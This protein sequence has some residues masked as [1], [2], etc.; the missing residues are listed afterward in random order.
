MAECRAEQ[1]R[2]A[3]PGRASWRSVWAPGDGVRPSQ[4]RE[5]GPWKQVSIPRLL[6]T[7]ECFLRFS[8]DMGHFDPVGPQRAHGEWLAPVVCWPTSL[9]SDCSSVPWRGAAAGVG[10]VQRD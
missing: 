7:P 4:Q 1:G 5:N 8:G 10:G 3:N 6:W 2:G 9:A